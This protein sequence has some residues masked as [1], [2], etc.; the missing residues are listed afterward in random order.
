MSEPIVYALKHP[1]DI[2]NKEGEAIETITSLT[3]VRP[4]GRQLKAMDRAEGEVGKTIALV[5][6]IAGLP[7]SAGDLLDGEDI[8]D[9]GEILA[10]FFGGRRPTGGTFSAN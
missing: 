9:L 5:C 1:I 2:R 8:A 4:K 6:A 7:P 3:L 10:G